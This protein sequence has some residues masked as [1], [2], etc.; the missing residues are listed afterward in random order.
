MRRRFLGFI[1]SLAVL[2]I[3]YVAAW[4]SDLGGP[5]G[6]MAD[7]SYPFSVVFLPVVAVVF[8]S[9]ILFG[10]ILPQGLLARFVARRLRHPAVPFV[11]FLSVSGLLVAPVALWH[12]NGSPIWTFAWG[13]SYLTAGCC[14]LWLISFRYDNVGQKRSGE[15]P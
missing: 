7:D 15:P 6:V 14:V 10:V 2:A 13:V 4:V 8:S 12:S 1:S 5:G 11:V 3:I 9:V